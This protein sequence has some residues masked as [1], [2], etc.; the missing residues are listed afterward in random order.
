MSL[1]KPWHKDLVQVVDFVKSCHHQL[2]TAVCPW[3]WLKWRSP[4][5]SY[6]EPD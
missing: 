2:V 5:F 1:S 4:L 6:L 3:N